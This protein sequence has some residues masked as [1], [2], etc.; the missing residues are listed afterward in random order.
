VHHAHA[1][2]R[3]VGVAMRDHCA[4]NWTPRIDVEIA[5]A[6]VKTFSREFE[7]L[8]HIPSMAGTQ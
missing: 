7:E 3:V 1:G 2:A 5:G 8:R 6:A 4:R